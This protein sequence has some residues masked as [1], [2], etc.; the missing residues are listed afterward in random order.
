MKSKKKFVIILLFVF[1]FMGGGLSIVIADTSISGVLSTW[2]SNKTEQSIQTIETEIQKEQ[3]KQTE[4][5]K[6]ELQ[7]S[8]DQLENE[9]NVFVETEK[10]KRITAIEMYA[11]ELLTQITVD[12]LDRKTEIEKEL[13]NIYQEAIERMDVISDNQKGGASKVQGQ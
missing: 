10:Q 2:L 12:G 6:T 3:G 11:E 1:A 4:R 7:A 8:I 5:L 9:L 13:D